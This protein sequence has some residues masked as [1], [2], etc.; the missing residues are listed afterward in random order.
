M[1]NKVKLIMVASSLALL[2][3]AC[4]EKKA[5]GQVV[6]VV[7]GEEISQEELNA[8]LQAQSIMP[9][10]DKKQLQ[11]QVLQRLIER[12]LL[13]QKAK[14]DGLDKTPEFIIQSRRMQDDLAINML[15]QKLGKSVALPDSAAVSRFIANNPTLFKGRKR[16]ALDQIAFAPPSNMAVLRQLEPAHSL[17]AVAA[18]LTTAGIK[19][20]QGS[21]VLDTATVPPELAQR[22]ASLP[23]G[24]PFVVP[25]GGRFVV[26]VVKSVQDVPTADSEA[27]P[28][29]IELIR[30]TNIESAVRKE[31]ETARTAAKIEYRSDFGPPAKGGAPKPAA[32]APAAPAPA[33]PAPGN[34]Q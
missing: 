21:S 9:S 26:S 28:A 8:E 34:T 22:I 11:N 33:A 5:T 29:A 24:E 15:S 19:F 30:R 23:P 17:E 3:S 16:Y 10:A 7:N 1:G 27:Q 6:A 32:P 25:A 18:A 20:T 2:L 31:L 13:A 4:G 12:K 14:Q